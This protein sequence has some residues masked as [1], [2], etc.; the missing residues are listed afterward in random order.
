MDIER[1][2]MPDGQWA[3]I[4]RR[5]THGQMKQIEKFTRKAI[6]D[7]EWLSTQDALVLTLV[8]KWSF[9]KPVSREAI[10]EMPH[11]IIA[12][13][14]DELNKVV[15]ASQTPSPPDREKPRRK[16]G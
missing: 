1:F 3:D 5:P 7:E 15:E 6:A 13:I 10:D 9:D 4:H 2:D 12:L 8:D 14:S 11:A 16:S